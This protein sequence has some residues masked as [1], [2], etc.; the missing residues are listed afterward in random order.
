[1]GKLEGESHVEAT[2]NATAKIWYRGEQRLPGLMESVV[3]HPAARNIPLW[4]LVIHQTINFQNIDILI[5]TG[6][7]PP[8]D[9]WVRP[10]MFV[11]LLTLILAQTL[12]TPTPSNPS[13]SRPQLP[14]SRKKK[15]QCNCVTQNARSSWSGGVLQNTADM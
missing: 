13:S 15:A 1:L 10:D 7:Q 8:E 9:G 6:L 2:V 4:K 3:N 11:I 12:Y 14:Q 5:S